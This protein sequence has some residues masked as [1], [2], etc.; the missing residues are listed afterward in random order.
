MALMSLAPARTVAPRASIAPAVACAPQRIS[1]TPCGPDRS[2]LQP[3]IAFPSESRNGHAHLRSWWPPV[4]CFSCAAS[5]P[6]VSPVSLSRTSGLA[7]F[8]IPHRELGSAVRTPQDANPG[9]VSE[10][11]NAH[12]GRQVQRLINV[13]AALAGLRSCQAVDL[14]P[15]ARDTN[16]PLRLSSF[17]RRN[18]SPLPGSSPTRAVM[19]YR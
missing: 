7:P 12:H 10:S 13:I 11:S 3:S 2:S 1:R 15:P 16:H 6:V 5:R 18:L 17:G 19:S 4:C 14:P 9:C 8:S